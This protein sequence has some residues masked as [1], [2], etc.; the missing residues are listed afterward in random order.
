M[1][2]QLEDEDGVALAPDDPRIQLSYE[3]GVDGQPD[4]RIDNDMLPEAGTP[5]GVSVYLKATT[6]G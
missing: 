4:I 6:M 1:K 3:N 2:Y 5:E